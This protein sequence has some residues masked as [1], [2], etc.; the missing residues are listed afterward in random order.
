MIET[1]RILGGF[2]VVVLIVALAAWVRLIR[3]PGLRRLDGQVER[4]PA[5]A[6]I[7]SR[8]SLLAVATSALAAVIAVLNRIFA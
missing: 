7:A 4:N 2:S 1:A 3:E 5:Q 6:E 8:L